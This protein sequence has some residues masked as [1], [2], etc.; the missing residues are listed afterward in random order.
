MGGFSGLNQL[1][2]VLFALQVKDSLLCETLLGL[3]VLPEVHSSKVGCWF[4]HSDSMWDAESITH[5]NYGNQ[6]GLNPSL[7]LQKGVQY[8]KKAVEV[9]L[10]VVIMG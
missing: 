5:Q 7:F 10:V 1:C 3:P 8:L 9:G 6:D 4:C 2:K